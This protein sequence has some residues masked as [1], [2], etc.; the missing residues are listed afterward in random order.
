MLM[1]GLGGASGSGG[2]AKEPSVVESIISKACPIFL[3]SLGS[4]SKRL[5]VSSSSAAPRMYLSRSS[6]DPEGRGGCCGT[7]GELFAEQLA[8]TWPDSSASLLALDENSAK[9]SE[10]VKSAKQSEL[11]KSVS[12]SSSGKAFNSRW[13]EETCAGGMANRLGL[14]GPV[15]SIDCSIR[16]D[17]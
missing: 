6:S 16:D 17:G 4:T 1:V 2:G 14:T 5:P 9:Q 10:L 3:P 15:A 11:V 7:T 12:R 8:D 13:S